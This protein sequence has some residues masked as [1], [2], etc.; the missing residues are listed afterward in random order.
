MDHAQPPRAIDGLYDALFSVRDLASGMQLAWLPV[1]DETA[2]TTVDALVA[3]FEADGPPLVLKSDN[4]PA[5]KSGLV[6]RLLA[7]RGVVPLRS[8]PVTPE[9]NGSCE[10]GIGAMKVRTHYQAARHG[11]S[12]HWTCEETEA[13]RCQA[14]EYHYPDRPAHVT[15]HELWQ[16]RAEIDYTEREQFHLAVERALHEQ[17]NKRPC[18]PEEQPTAAQQ[19]AEHRRAVRQALVELGILS[20]QWRSITLPIKPRKSAKIS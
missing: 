1:P 12:G 16:S 13:A 10:A 8:P 7:D 11:R 6:A 2:E 15:P 20:T 17:H 3:L 18:D 19:A 14:N 5:F 9:Y 4:G